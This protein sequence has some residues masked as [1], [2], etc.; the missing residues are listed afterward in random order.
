[1]NKVSNK[2]PP[3]S[4]S[5]SSINNISR[6]NI[7]LPLLNYD[8]MSTRNTSLNNSQ[9]LYTYSY[10]ETSDFGGSS[11]D[12]R[13]GGLNIV[14]QNKNRNY[15]TPE[16]IFSTASYRIKRRKSNAIQN[17]LIQAAAV[18]KRPQHILVKNTKKLNKKRSLFSK[19]TI[20]FAALSLGG[21][22]SRVNVNNGGDI[23]SIILN[24]KSKEKKK[25]AKSLVANEKWN[26][27]Y[28]MVILLIVF[29]LSALFIFVLLAVCTDPINRLC[30]SLQ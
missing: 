25:N 10:V 14:D 28:L 29:C 22:G 8:T 21:G 11:H 9:I 17:N 13:G 4:S 26:C 19:K 20:Q 24:G 23:K 15:L 18:V 6:N 3:H 2:A 27:I 7:E 1:M 16:E 5:L 30:Y 12:I